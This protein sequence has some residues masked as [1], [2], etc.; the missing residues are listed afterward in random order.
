MMKKSHCTITYRL[1]QNKSGNDEP[2]FEA[3]IGDS[4]LGAKFETQIW[5]PDLGAKFGIQV[6]SPNP[7]FG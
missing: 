4:N 2:K 1:K 5:E 6:W 7:S 3:Q